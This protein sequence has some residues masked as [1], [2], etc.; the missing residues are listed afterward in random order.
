MKPTTKRDEVETIDGRV[1]FSDDNW[2]TVWKAHRTIGRTTEPR[3]V[4]DRQECDFARF[5]AICK[6]NG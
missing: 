4:T 1:Y 3:R 2:Q 5:L 6:E